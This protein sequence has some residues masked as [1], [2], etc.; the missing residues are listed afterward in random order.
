VRRGV[1][2]GAD[3]TAETCTHPRPQAEVEALWGLL[4]AGRVDQVTSDHVGWRPERKAAADVFDARAGA[5]GVELL[6]PLLW[7]EG[8]VRRHLPVGRLVAALYKTP[9]R[10]FGLW[11]RKGAIAVDAD[12]DFAVVKTGT[13]GRVDERTLESD[14]GWSP[15][16]G[17]ETR[18]RVTLT[19]LR[20]REVARNGR[21]TAGSLSGRVIAP[22]RP[23]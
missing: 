12:A 14:A 17:I 5:P 18:A 9:A 20:G 21:W 4:A 16:H 2:D 22:E 10:R 15:Y 19:I 8:V 3:A 7:S 1:Q 23:R 13:A 6:L 11:P